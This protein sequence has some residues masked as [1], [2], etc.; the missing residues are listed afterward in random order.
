MAIYNRWLPAFLSAFMPVFLAALWIIFAPIQM[1]GQSAYVIITGNSM[2]PGFHTGDLVIVQPAPAYNIGDIVAYHNAD[3]ERYVF[4]RIIR[5]ELNRFVLQGDNNTWIDA[6]QPTQEKLIGKLWIHLPSAGKAVQWARLP[7]NMSIIA[8]ALA[9]LLATTLLL[10]QQRHGRRR[11]SLQE[12]F[13][14]KKMVI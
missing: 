10:G 13:N 14:V 4:H 6:Y 12:W 11:K 9:G 3:L 5:K 7:I 1:G 8:G 2:E